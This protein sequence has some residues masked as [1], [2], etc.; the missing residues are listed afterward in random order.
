MRLITVFTPTYNRAFCLNQLYESLIVQTNKDFIW[1]IID[2]GSTDGTTELI[3]T[4]QNENKLEIHYV[5]Q[6][7][8]GM[9]GAHNTAY[10]NITTELNVCIDSDD[11]MPHDAI[12]KILKIWNEKGSDV[13]A[14][15]IGLDSFNDG[16]IVGSTI[17][18]NIEISTLNELYSV[19]KVTGDKKM[20]LRTDVVKQFPPYPIYKGEKLVPL[21]T[22]YLM[23][24][25]K[26]K[27]ICSNEVFCI[28]EYLEDG[29]SKN[30][31]KQYIK[32]PRGFGYSR[33]VTMRLSNSLSVQFKAAIHLVSSALFARS[34]K[35]FFQSPNLVISILA[36]PF[37]FL[38]TGYIIF[39]TRNI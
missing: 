4:W 37:G 6:E 2:D 7:N 8:Q 26:Y 16:A 19:H 13:L 23:I 11:Y 21:G 5:F 28:V 18:Q 29:S 31:L 27:C 12:E 39:K 30:I 3:R 17:P 25:T 9:H 35:L 20:V 32:S 33:I 10:Q 24:G 15:I 34:I 22:L 38:L 14:G 36:I 1:L